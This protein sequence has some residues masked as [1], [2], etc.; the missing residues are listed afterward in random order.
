MW[1]MCTDHNRHYQVLHL[2]TDEL[3][4]LGRHLKGFI[5]MLCIMCEIRADESWAGDGT[6]DFLL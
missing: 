2:C 4:P 3:Q 1:L 5:P 6:R